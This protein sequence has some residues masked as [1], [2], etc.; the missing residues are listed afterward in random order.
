MPTVH[1]TILELSSIPAAIRRTSG[2]VM[3]DMASGCP[4]RRLTGYVAICCMPS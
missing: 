1:R 2:R 4:P 3:G